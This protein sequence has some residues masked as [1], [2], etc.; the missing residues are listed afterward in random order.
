MALTARE[1]AKTFDLPDTSVVVAGDWHGN[2]DW[3]GLALPAAARTGARTMLHLGD[4]GFWPGESKH[5]LKS[6][7]YW[8]SRGLGHPGVD[9]ILVTRGNHEDWGDLDRVFAE[10]PGSA[11]RVSA[12]VWVLPRGFRFTIGNRSFL[13]FGGAASIDFAARAAG[14]TWWLSEI[15]TVLEAEQ[16]AS[17]GEVDVLLTH[18]VGG[19][20]GFRV[21]KTIARRAGDWSATAD[22]Y[23]TYS[24]YLVDSVLLGTHPRIHLHGHYH[25]RD[26]AI[27]ALRGT[28]FVQVESLA[29]DGQ[30]GNMI[31]LDLVIMS[32]TDLDPWRRVPEL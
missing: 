16:A 8:A 4:F 14:K 30:P 20:R 10:A 31:V 5:L 32:A 19:V 27:Q 1:V 23:A 26:S 7:D 12:R 6:L 2:Q 17:S 13:S 9:R 25:V 11:V 18:D 21:K 29:M 3:I 22:V 24:R 28:E 15:A